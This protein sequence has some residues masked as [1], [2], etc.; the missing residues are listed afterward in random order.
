MKAIRRICIPRLFSSVG[1]LL[2][3]SVGASVLDWVQGRVTHQ[4]DHTHAILAT[5]AWRDETNGQEPGAYARVSGYLD[6]SSDAPASHCVPRYQRY[7]C[8]PGRYCCG[9]RRRLCLCLLFQASTIREVV[10][11]MG[12]MEETTGA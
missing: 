12:S 6:C 10:S 7:P 3:C 11:F 5:P 2:V 9:Y 8:A 4:G 1:F